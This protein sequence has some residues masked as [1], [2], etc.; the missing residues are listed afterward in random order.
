MTTTDTDFVS[1]E[2]ILQ[3]ILLV[4]GQRVLLDSDLAA[5][6]GVPT[7][8]LNEQVKRNLERFPGDFMFR[9][10]C[11]EV[12]ALNRSQF[13]TGSRKHRDRRFPPYAFTEHGAIMVAT[14]LS[15]SRAVETSIYVVRAF[16]Q[17]RGVLAA[18]TE[19]AQRVTKLERGHQS[20]DS[21]I[22]G[23]LKT[24]HEMRNVP[25]TRAIGFVDLDEKK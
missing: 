2:S 12:E 7:K 5:L 25:Q 11:D 19:I 10:T 13:A 23:I 3:T 21:A 4:Q 16:V 8:R 22:V 17:L 24:L 15:S 6:Y 9:L 1:I 18:G 14:L 20:H